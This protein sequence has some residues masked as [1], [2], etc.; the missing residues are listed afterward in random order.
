MSILRGIW[1]T[2]A[3]VANTLIMGIPLILITLLKWVPGLRTPVTHVL[4]WIADQWGAQNDALLRFGGALRLSIVGDEPPSPNDWTLIISNH[5]TWVDI[6]V[7]HCTLTR[8]VAPI[9][10][11]LKSELIWLPIIGIACWALDFPFMKRYSREYLERHPERRGKD[12][13]ATRRA[14]AAFARRPASLLNFLEGTRLT[15]AKHRAQQSPFP[16]LLKPRAG[17]LAFVL[18]SLGDRM[19]HIVD[20]TIVYP[21]GAPS[22]WSF[23]C[24]RCPE[25]ILHLQNRPVPR[26]L[27]SGDYMDDPAFREALQ[28]WVTELWAEKERRLQALLT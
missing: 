15:A 21:Q 2:S 28:T 25:V 26:D 14:C 19:D 27:S 17:G 5:Q 20:A 12:L 9:K 13:E 1:N 22:F 18:A 4:V 24:G 7:L 3:I 11:F 23:M 16:H 10:F 8:R 6:F